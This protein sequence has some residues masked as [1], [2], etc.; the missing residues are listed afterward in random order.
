MR[1]ED[2]NGLPIRHEV[3]AVDVGG[4]WTRVALAGPDG[5]RK[6]RREPTPY[7]ERAGAETDLVGLLARMIQESLGSARATPQAVGVSVTGPVDV[8]TGVLYAPPNAPDLG[9]LALSGPLSERLGLP[10]VLERDTNAALLAEVAL[11]AAAGATDAVFITVSTGVGG[12]ALVDGHLLRGRDGVAGELGHVVVQPGGPRCGCGRVGCLE[13]VASGS[14][15]ARAAARMAAA[16]PESPLGQLLGRRRAEG[17]GRLTGT[18][19]ASAAADGD[20]S[21]DALLAA[22]GDAVVSA[23]VDAVN[24]FNPDVLV[25]GGTIARAHPEWVDRARQAVSSSALQPARATAHVRAAVL[26]EAAEL[27]GAAIV[28][29]RLR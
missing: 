23:A 19:V 13:A 5:L 25:I 12:A 22:A 6:Q 8:T 7:G 27:V 15:L 20:E 1:T 24:T 26:G 4:T 10:V 9:G 2:V 17:A 16:R 29:D 14:G 21:A 3:V 28:A 18:D 11:G